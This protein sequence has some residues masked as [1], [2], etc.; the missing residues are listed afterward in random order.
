M[1]KKVFIVCKLNDAGIKKLKRLKDLEVVVIPKPTSEELIRHISD[2]EGMIIKSNV[3]FPAEVLEHAKNLKVIVRAGA[4]VDNVDL[5]KATQ[6]GIPVCNTPGLNSNSVAEQV[7]GY[8]NA[9]YKNII[10]Y[11]RTTKSGAWEK[12]RYTINELRGKTIGI[13]GLGAIGRRVL[14]KAK[15]YRMNAIVF[16]PFI[17]RTLAQDLGFELVSNII[18]LFKTCDIVTVH[19]P[20]TAE[21]K[22]KITRDTLKAMKKNAIFINTA[23]GALLAPNAME[24]ALAAHSTLKAGIDVYLDEGMGEKALAKFGDRVVMTPHIS[25]NSLEGQVEISELVA[26]IVIDAVTKNKLRNLVNFI[27]IPEELDQAYLDLAESLG[28][29]GCCLT[30]HRGQLEEVSITCYGALNK[31]KEILV[32]P[33]IKGVL[34][35]IVSENVTLINAENIAGE[36]GTKIKRRRPPNSKGY[37]NSIT[38]DVI[39]REGKKTIETSIRGKLIEGEPVIVRINEYHELG[40]KP[41]GN[42][43]FF[44]YDNKPGVI[45]NIATQVGAND[46]N[47]E[48]ILAR[49]DVKKGK[50]QLLVIRTEQ[51]INTQLLKKLCKK[52]ETKAGIKIYSANN[53]Q[54]AG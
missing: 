36:L 7:F 12:G 13:A 41:Q 51:P 2:A 38:V 46:I 6:M 25:G 24:D 48:S 18:Q 44:Q 10:T 31:F 47:I 49:N 30:E 39:V 5:K 8:I 17:S 16:D 33:A 22:G 26:D 23:R 1:K 11:D 20:A 14:E 43:L 3:K 9:L 42:Q 19:M 34:S 40:I 15:G 37:G 50:K 29:L 28:Y 54:C 21:T 35:G 32:K 53:V 27:Q 45:G 4:G 52:V